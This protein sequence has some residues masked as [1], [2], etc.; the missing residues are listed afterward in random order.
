M[1]GQGGA[2]CG[3][4]SPARS[5]G[6]PPPSRAGGAGSSRGSAGA[7]GSCAP[8]RSGGGTTASSDRCRP[9]WG[10]GGV[11]HELA[12]VLGRP[13]PGRIHGG[14]LR[15]AGRRA[16]HHPVRTKPAEYLHRQVTEQVR[17]PR[18]AAG[19]HH[20]Q[21]LR[22]GHLGERGGAVRVVWVGGDPNQERNGEC[23]SRPHVVG[24]HAAHHTH[25]GGDGQPTGAEQADGLPGMVPLRE[26]LPGDFVRHE[27]ALAS[28]R[29][30]AATARTSNGPPANEDSS[31]PF[32]KARHIAYVGS[33]RQSLMPCLPP[34]SP[35]G[36]DHARRDRHHR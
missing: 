26:V 11:E 7:D 23:G 36:A 28:G 15:A 25:T 2:G 6:R 30:T 22:G 5:N 1:G 20:H 17:D 12:A 19:V 9:G 21:H 18:D 13:A 29:T 4:R 3:R 10:G 14:E 31:A 34:S 27:S 16:A 24:A 32:A 35:I 33:V 8:G